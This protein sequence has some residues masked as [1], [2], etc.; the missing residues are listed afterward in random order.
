MA[1]PAATFTSYGQNMDQTAMMESDQLI[2]VNEKDEI[3]YANGQTEFLSKKKGHS[4]SEKTP[5]GIL[6]RAFS[7]FLFD[8]SGERMLLTQ[9]AASKITF[10]SVWTNSCC[11][12]PLVGMIPDEVDIVAS[13]YPH[14]PGI[15]HAAVR[16]LQ[17]ELGIDQLQ[18]EF[19]KIQF[20]SR[21]HYWATDTLSNR[22]NSDPPT[23]GE[24]EIDYILFYQL[25]SGM[26]LEI[27]PNPDE[28]SEYKFVS[29]L[30]LQAMMGEPNLLWS[31]W[32]RGIM[33]RGGWDWWKDLPGVFAGSH[34]NESISFFDPP[35]EHVAS[36]NL[37]SHNRQTGMLSTTN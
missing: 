29:M 20:V 28:V 3:V 15:K 16:K 17:Q 23:W 9:R 5:R 18:I 14:F 19:D 27:R 25:P 8:A 13:S 37:P 12:H 24:H 30:E 2:A 10:P 34:T 26:N 7:F 33:E 21:F 11:S 35:K 32:F 1:R 6:H 4:F 36:Y 31:P 22:E